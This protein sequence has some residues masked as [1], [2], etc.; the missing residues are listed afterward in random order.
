MK[1]GYKA[2]PIIDRFEEKI[3]Y[4]PDGCWLWIGQISKS[5]YP[6]QVRPKIKIGQVPEIASRFSYRHYKGEIPAGLCVL[7]KCD[8]P[9]CVNPGHL[10][11][12]T[13]KEN[14]HDMMSKGR[15]PIGNKHYKAILTNE[16]VIDIKASN[17]KPAVLARKYG[18]DTRH[19]CSIKSGRIWR[20]INIDELKTNLPA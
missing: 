5:K 2:R 6:S 15:K 14:T 18:I 7:H 4:S 16:A 12:G 9:I 17:E 20:H 1:R 8:N 13:Q 11:L 19:V 3:F 10:F